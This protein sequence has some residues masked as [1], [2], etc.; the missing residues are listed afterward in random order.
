MILDDT[1]W[2]RAEYLLSFTEPIM[3]MI[4]YTDMDH[5]CLGEVYDGIDSMLEKMKHVINE[6]KQDPKETFFKELQKI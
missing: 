2:E 4:R 6:K 5:P 1:W 3:S